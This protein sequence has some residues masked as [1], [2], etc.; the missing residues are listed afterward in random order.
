MSGC[1]AVNTLHSGFAQS[2][3]LQKN[4]LHCTALHCTTM[5]C[6]AMQSATGNQQP[7]VTVTVTTTAL[8]L[9]YDN[10]QQIDRQMK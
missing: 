6:N 7:A 1:Q 10:R 4:Y 5:Q 9:F 8:K 2:A 3:E